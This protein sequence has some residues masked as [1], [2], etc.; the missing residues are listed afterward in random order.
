MGRGREREAEGKRREN[1]NI[2]ENLRVCQRPF[3]IGP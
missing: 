1:M 2:R 3:N